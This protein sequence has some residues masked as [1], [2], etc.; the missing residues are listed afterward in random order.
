M[1]FRTELCSEKRVEKS[2]RITNM[3]C[4]TTWNAVAAFNLKMSALQSKIIGMKRSKLKY[5]AK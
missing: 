1:L 3:C 2:F 4:L 5:V